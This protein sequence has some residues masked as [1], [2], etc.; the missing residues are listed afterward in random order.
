MLA[1]RM[2]STSMS[3]WT[4]TPP[5]RRR[6]SGHGWR[7]AHATMST[8][9]RRQ[10][11]GSIRSSAGSAELTRKQIQ[12]GVHTSVHQLEADIRAFIEAHNIDPKPYR[13]TKSADE[14]LA[15]IKRVATRQTL[16]YAANF[17]FRRRVRGDPGRALPGFVNPTSRAVKP[18]VADEPG[19]VPGASCHVVISKEA[20]AAGGDQGRQLHGNGKDTRHKSRNSRAR[21]S[22]I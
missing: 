7:D 18:I 22:A 4:T 1:F 17:R 16:R 9:R 8:S 14:I 2:T 13:W 20:I 6:G 21:S 3:S 15:S 11:P 5:T 19:F 12:R 10:H